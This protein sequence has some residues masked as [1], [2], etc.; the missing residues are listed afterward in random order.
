MTTTEQP[1]FFIFW[2]SIWQFDALALE[3][4]FKLSDIFAACTNENII[5]VEMRTP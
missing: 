2:L 3:L 5:L 1:D 4:G